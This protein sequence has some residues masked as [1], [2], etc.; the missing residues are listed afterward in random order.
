MGLSGRRMDKK[1]RTRLDLKQMMESP[2]EVKP[3]ARAP[4]N[5]DD[6][7]DGAATDLLS[8][9]K[10][11]KNQVRPDEVGNPRE[12]Q[13]RQFLQDWLPDRYGVAHGYVINRSSEA[14][15]QMDC[16]VYDAGTC[17]K[18]FQ[19]KDENRRLFPIGYTYAA[20]EVKSVL[21]QTELKDALEKVQSVGGLTSLSRHGTEE[22][23]TIDIADRYDENEHHQDW[24]KVGLRKWIRPHPPITAI[25]AFKLGDDLTIDAIDRTCTSLENLHRPDLILI[26]DGGCIIKETVASMVR[27][28]SLLQGRNS[29]SV[30]VD[31]KR[32]IKV[33]LN[34]HNGGDTYEC[35]KSD[36]QKCNLMTFFAVFLDLINAIELPKY[37][38]TDLISIWRKKSHK[39]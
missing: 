20:V 7:F 11:S 31:W 36:D 16:V 24:R 8:A 28:A 1:I 14:S 3:K 29:E 33:M 35:L 22:I 10:K 18:F 15:R 19:D 6:L 25:I 17:P 23:S 32:R 2:A 9:F 34:R 38:A 30:D 4:F 5:F 26:L 39:K 13:V 12:R 27:V 37:P 21:G